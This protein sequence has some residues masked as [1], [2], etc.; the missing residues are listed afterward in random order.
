MTEVP[1]HAHRA[2]SWHLVLP[3][4]V[5]PHWVGLW[6]PAHHVTLPGAR[7]C[8][9]V[10]HASRPEKTRPKKKGLDGPH[11]ACCRSQPGIRRGHR[12]HALKGSALSW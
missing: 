10:E 4:R 3:H 11:I 2:T 6:S 12:K 5:Y 9:C 1:K 7:M 8:E